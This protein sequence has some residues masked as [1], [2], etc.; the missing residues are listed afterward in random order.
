MLTA[1]IDFFEIALIVSDK[2]N[3]GSFTSSQIKSFTVNS[4]V[5]LN[6]SHTGRTTAGRYVDL[7]GEGIHQSLF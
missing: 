1:S 5:L 3:A 2:V 7:S 6:G 4:A